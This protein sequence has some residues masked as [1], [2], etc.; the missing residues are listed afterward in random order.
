MRRW[1]STMTSARFSA[2]GN[3]STVRCRRRR[4]WRSTSESAALSADDSRFTWV[5]TLVLVLMLVIRVG[6]LRGFGFQ[7]QPREQL[8]IAS[9]V[10]VAGGEQLLAVEHRVRAG[11]EAQR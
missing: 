4:C 3:D 6:H 8:L 7:S 1:P 9:H 5:V 11:H 2:T 10:R